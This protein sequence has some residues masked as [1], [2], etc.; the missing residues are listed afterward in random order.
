MK[1]SKLE[2][3]ETVNKLRRQKNRSQKKLESERF[4]NSR[5]KHCEIENEAMPTK[6]WGHSDFK[7]RHKSY[8]LLIQSENGNNTFL[9]MQSLKNVLPFTF[10]RN[11]LEASAMEVKETGNLEQGEVTEINSR[12]VGA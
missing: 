3:K 5:Y 10:V 9:D 2:I 7:W 12:V 11:L 8:K 4:S 1:F 6:F